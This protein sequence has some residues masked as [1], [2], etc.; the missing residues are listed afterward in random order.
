MNT[1]PICLFVYNRPQATESVLNSLSRCSGAD[2]HDVFIFADALRLASPDVYEDVNQVRQIIRRPYRFRSVTIREAETNKGLARSIIEEVT[3]VIRRHARVAATGAVQDARILIIHQENADVSA[4]RNKGIEEAICDLI[5]FL[6]ED[7]RWKPEYLQTQYELQQKC[8]ESSV[9]ACNYEFVY[10]DDSTQLPI[11]RKLSFAGQDGVLPNYS[12]VE[13]CLHSPIRSIRIMGP[14][15]QCMLL[16]TTNVRVCS[17][18][19][20]SVTNK[21]YITENDLR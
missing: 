15:T 9:F 4:I 14:K 20:S 5:G 2:E 21:D 1:T 18:R 6:D 10:E 16:Q 11:I 19:V 7:A 17:S 13:S 12:E 8:P 3:D